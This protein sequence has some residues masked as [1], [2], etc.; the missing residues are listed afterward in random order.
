MIFIFNK[1]YKKYEM[2]KTTSWAME[3]QPNEFYKTSQ[4]MA[5]AAQPLEISPKRVLSKH[6][7]LTYCSPTKESMM[8][9]SSLKILLFC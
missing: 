9:C 2:K 7:L 3:P 1:Y 5:L 4:Q 6:W 8:L